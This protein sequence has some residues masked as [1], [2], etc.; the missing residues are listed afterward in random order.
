MVSE[1]ERNETLK[2]K[3]KPNKFGPPGAL[4]NGTD[5]ENLINK[6]E[7]GSAE[8]TLIFESRFESGNLF[9]AQRVSDNEYNLLMQNDINT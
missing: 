8:K 2:L 6:L 7:E 9:L 5:T 1:Y 4:K 3:R